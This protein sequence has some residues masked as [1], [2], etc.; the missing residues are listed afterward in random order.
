M[1]KI[2]DLVAAMLAL[3]SA[4][5][6]QEGDPFGA[7][8]KG[9]SPNCGP[10]HRYQFDERIQ[11]TRDFITFVKKHGVDLKDQYGNRW[12]QLD[13]FKTIKPGMSRAQM[14]DA[15]VDWAKAEKT[16]VTEKVGRRTVYSLKFEPLMCPAQGFTLKATDDGYASLYG[17]C[18]K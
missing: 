7:P 5:A 11:S 17:C 18:G 13:D 14:L 3:V 15:P 4:C 12:V 10:E 16:V 6:A 2:A 9:V 8:P 1:K